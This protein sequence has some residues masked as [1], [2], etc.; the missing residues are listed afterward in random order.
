MSEANY[1]E[2]TVSGTSWQRV[3]ACHIF[4]DYGQTPRL[5]LYEEKITTLDG[6][7]IRKHV[8]DFCITFD[9]TNEDH[10][11]LYTLLNKIY[12]EQRTI[13]DTPPV[14]EEPIVEPP[15]EP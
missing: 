6:E 14:I 1:N 2:S 3:Y 13:R 8:Q 9:P 11:A 4:N 10:L 15:V 7:I 5:N 12:V